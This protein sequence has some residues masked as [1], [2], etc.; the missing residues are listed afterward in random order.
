MKEFAASFGVEN[1]ASPEILPNTH[2]ILAMAEYAREMGTLDVFRT[3]AMRA[4]WE[5]NRDLE[6]DGV[7]SDLAEA[8]GLDPRQALAASNSM[9]YLAR[10]DSLGTE[11]KRMGITGIP[12]FIIGE[13]HIVGCQPYQV[14]ADTVRQAGGLPRK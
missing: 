10:V 1:I 14:L 9:D 13:T 12:T 2:R 7:L 6:D 8:S 11:A 3:L 4:R 5:E